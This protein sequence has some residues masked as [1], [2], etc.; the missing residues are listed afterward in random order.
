MQ[1]DFCPPVSLDPIARRHVVPSFH[2]S[3]AHDPIRIP[4]SHK[5]PACFCLAVAI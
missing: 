4:M 5:H 1:E 3:N 2:D